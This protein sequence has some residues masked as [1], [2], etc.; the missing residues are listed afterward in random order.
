MT[1]PTHSPLNIPPLNVYEEMISL[2][3]SKANPTVIA[4]KVI[5]LNYDIFAKKFHLDFNH[6]IHECTFPSNHN[7]SISVPLVW[8]PVLADKDIYRPV[9]ILP[10]TSKVF[11]QLLI[12]Q[13]NKYMGAKLSK[14]QCG[15]R[16]GYSSQHCLLIMLEKWRATLD[17]KGSSGVIN[18]FIKSI[19]QL[20]A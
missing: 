17:K 8:S 3:C 15:F 4:A 2:N 19:R 9:S 18:R 12:L 16:K 13:I 7:C 1:I 5:N 14:Y 11:E 20:V 10:A 6:A